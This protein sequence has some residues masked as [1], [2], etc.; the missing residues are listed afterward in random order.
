MNKN[1]R[2]RKTKNPCEKCFL[3]RNLCVCEFIPQLDLR[4]RLCLVV[5]YKELKRTTNTGRL[6]VESLVNSEMRIRGKG[7]QALDLSDLLNEKYQTWMFYPSTDA[8]ELTSS[9]IA[10]DPRPVQL[11][12]PDGNWR[13]ASKVHARH[14]E[15]V[16]VPRVKISTPNHA[17]AHLRTETTDEGMA[18]L[19]AIAK[20]MAIIE[21]EATAA[22]LAKLFEMKLNRT[23]QGRGVKLPSP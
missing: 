16:S 19:E 15:L 3:H 22:P 21:G 8:Q 9:L 6:A 18:T 5:H 23:L 17:S 7:T 14:P 4:T 2:K 10:Q 12:V 11:I 1:D 20:A 13:Q